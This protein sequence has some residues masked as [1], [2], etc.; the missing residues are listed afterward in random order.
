VRRFTPV[1]KTDLQVQNFRSFFVCADMIRNRLKR[2]QTMH[3]S[4]T[5]V[6][7]G[8]PPPHPAVALV[9]VI[10]AA[11]L[12]WGAYPV[13][14]SPL[15]I[16]V[17][18]VPL[19]LLCRA[20]PPTAAFFSGLAY[21]ALAMQLICH[22]IYVVPDF[23]WYHGLPLALYL[24][25]FPAVWC[26]CCSL[27]GRRQCS[28]LLPGAALWVLLDYGKAHAGFL[29]FPWATLAH[30][31]Y[32]VTPLLQISSMTGEYGVGFLIVLANIALVEWLCDR[33]S[34]G[35][36]GVAVLL[37]MVWITGVIM[38]Q[39][40]TRP[41]ATTPLAITVVQPSIL[42]QERATPEGR[43]TAF[44]RLLEL[45][46]SAAA[47]GPDLI[48]LPETAV[49]HKETGPYQ[50]EAIG[51]IAAAYGLPI[52]FGASEGEKFTVDTGPAAPPAGTIA[53]SVRWYNSAYAAQP[54]GHLMEPYRKII[55]FPFGEFNPLPKRLTLPKWFLPGTGAIEAGTGYRLFTLGDTTTV[56]PAICWEIL[57]ADFFR[58]NLGASKPDLIA[59]LTNNNWFGRS[60]AAEQQNSAAVFRAIEN[61]VP[62]VV[63]SNT[64]P[65]Q[66]IDAHGRIIARAPELFQA[67]TVHAQT[68]PGTSYKQTCYHRFGNLFVAFCLILFVCTVALRLTI[69]VGSSLHPVP[70]IFAY[71]KKR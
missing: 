70:A 22:W 16:W 42:R 71:Q 18:L 48:V 5:T 1:R 19:I 62:V 7:Q 61:R 2:G 47:S 34:V 25:L 69:A 57:F 10:I 55:R 66:I 46:R 26:L 13:I 6:H 17:A 52:I 43:E 45:T 21:G 31:Q 3:V 36:L 39:T 49:R 44:S 38:L 15:L 20:L 4:R 29:S 64:G 53:V 58:G 40:D 68:T 24:G 28:F 32:E 8:E 41:T 50:L 37:G 59:N 27:F 60:A 63:A 30:S 56:A 12:T 9:A 51:S 67:S 23:R 11:L 14:G 33:R 35:A 65:S 54:D